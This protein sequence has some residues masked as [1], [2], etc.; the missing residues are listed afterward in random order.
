MDRIPIQ[1]LPPT[2]RHEAHKSI[3]KAVAKEVRDSESTLRPFAVDS[4]S[5]FLVAAARASWY[6]DL[7][8]AKSLLSRH[9][10][11][12]DVIYIE[13]GQIFF[14]DPEKFK[15]D[16]D[17]MKNEKLR[18]DRETTTADFAELPR[19][20]ANAS[21]L[22]G[23][24]ACLTRLAKLW[25]PIGRILHLSG[26]ILPSGDVVRGPKVRKALHTEW[27]PTFA[28]RETDEHLGNL[29][30]NR[31][32]SKLD[33]SLLETITIVSFLSFLC[34]VC[35]S[36]PGPDGLPYAAWRAVGF[37]G[38]ESLFLLYIYFTAG[39]LPPPSFNSSSFVFPPKGSSP[40]DRTEVIRSSRDTRPI[41]LK[42]SDN[43]TIAAVQNKALC[44]VLSEG[45]CSVQRGFIRGRNF[46]QNLVDL[47]V[48]GRVYSN[49][50]QSSQVYP[51]TESDCVRNVANVP[52]Y[53]FQDIAAAF[54]SLAHRFIF[55]VLRAVA[56]PTEL[57]NYI[58]ALYTGNVAVDFDGEI[59]F[60]ILSG[61]LQGCGMSGSLFALVFDP[62]LVALHSSL[63]V[64]DKGT[65]RGCADDVG[66][67][68]R[69]LRDIFKPYVVSRW[70]GSAANLHIN[71]KKTV[72]VPLCCKFSE[73]LAD[74]IREW[75]RLHVPGCGELQILPNSKYLGFFLGPNSG[76]SSWD[77]PWQK[78]A[79]RI[80]D[81]RVS[82][83]GPQ[84][85]A[86]TY[87]T[88]CLPVLGYQAQ[89]LE[90]PRGLIWK[91]RWALHKLFKISSTVNSE[92]FHSMNS[93]GAPTVMSIAAMG[94]SAIARTARQRVFGVPDL[95]RQLVRSTQHLSGVE[96]V[97]GTLC[98]NFW[99]WESFVSILYRSL[100]GPLP[101]LLTEVRLRAEN[102]IASSTA[103][104]VKMQKVF[105]KQYLDTLVYNSP[106]ADWACAIVDRLGRIFPD[107]LVELEAL[108]WSV[109]FAHLKKQP[110]SIVV[111]TLK[112]WTNVWTTSHRLHRTERGACV[113]GC[114]AAPDDL[115]HYARCSVLWEAIGRFAPGG[116]PGDDVLARLAL[117]DHDTRDFNLLAAAFH[118]YNKVNN[119]SVNARLL[120]LSEV[121]DCAR[122]AWKLVELSHGRVVEDSHTT[123]F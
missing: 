74:A 99:T 104:R 114:R 58:T 1:H 16:F 10:G 7:T 117:V 8:L 121:S 112:T 68:L 62:F 70:A 27:A 85:T 80:E 47:D 78:W 6:N 115:R 26:A 12:A 59:M 89:L 86:H 79:D 35:D 11:A 111:C 21:K 17:I 15:Q 23:K 107:L 20:E 66:I 50:F 41:S 43:K 106:R 28:E 67:A 55:I 92:H 61:I 108:D 56:A 13:G 25:V 52:V 81:I 49:E 31:F 76:R 94:F 30:A 33:W 51:P 77:A 102:R 3:L 72:I 29:V 40:S 24:M 75:L 34:S 54:P 97:A 88:K 38:A 69:K 39:N 57:I 105:Y 46:M 109:V 73:E 100:E 71:V 95:Y 96:W 93:L 42:N 53:F 44:K 84:V 32:C 113:F 119:A 48:V 82:G 123:A 122:A 101:P 98:R 83:V 37:A 90:I 22:R 60:K 9:P 64:L 63:D 103:T 19:T 116:P 2:Q 110:G 120:T 5:N 45:L 4:R 36:A 118:L 14:H 18:R 91:E 87:N 65:T